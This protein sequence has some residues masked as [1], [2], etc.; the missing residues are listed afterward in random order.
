MSFL[1]QSNAGDVD[2]STS[3]VS[4]AELADYA[5]DRGIDLSSYTDEQKEAALIQATDFMDT[6]YEYIGNPTNGDDQD[7]V[8]PRT[9]CSE[10]SDLYYCE[11]YDTKV[12]INSG[13]SKEIKYACIEYAITILGGTSLYTN[14]TVADSGIKVIDKKLGALQ[15]KIEYVGGSGS[16]TT[17]KVPKAENYLKR[18][19][20]LADSGYRVMR[21]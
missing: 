7:T 11:Y 5:T 9:Y 1:V 20:L 8:L 13:L 18:S 15:K 16:V 6:N 12:E 2:G 4:L 3:Y 19:G 14:V 10:N 17:T 21:S